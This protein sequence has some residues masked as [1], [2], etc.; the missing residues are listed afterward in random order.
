MLD[1][2]R[3]TL[4]LTYPRAGVNEPLTRI[5][6]GMHDYGTG[7]D[8]DSFH[9]VADFP[10]DG[11][12]PGENLAREFRPVAQGVREWKLSKGITQLP[13]G[14]LTVAVKDRQGN[15]T[16]VERTFSVGVPQP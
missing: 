14:K 7:L 15:V 10:V 11:K 16:R 4:T 9:V 12:A 3:P 5:L 6:V 8:E 1:D 2:Q 13:K